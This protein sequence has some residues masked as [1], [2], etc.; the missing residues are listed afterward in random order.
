MSN[1]V[2]AWG[3]QK[4]T[5]LFPSPV[6]R[7]IIRLII[8]CKVISLRNF[9]R[10]V[11]YQPRGVRQRRYIRTAPHTSNHSKIFTPNHSISK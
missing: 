1:V 4:E 2:P 9:F 6:T 8:K 5:T 11:K 10:L 3:A 7:M